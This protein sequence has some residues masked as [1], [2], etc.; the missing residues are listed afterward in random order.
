VP[1]HRNID[2]APLAL[3]S[4]RVLERGQSADVNP[5]D[6]EVAAHIAAGRLIPTADSA[7]ADSAERNTGSEPAAP[8]P[9][10]RRRTQEPAS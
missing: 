4:G 2:R 1:E 9:R 3:P 8:R 10:T 6:P 5:E 7:D